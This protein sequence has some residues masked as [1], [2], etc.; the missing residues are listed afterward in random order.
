GRCGREVTCA[1]RAALVQ[2]IGSQPPAKSVRSERKP[3]P[4]ANWNRIAWLYPDKGTPPRTGA[5]DQPSPKCSVLRPRSPSPDSW[6]VSIATAS[7]DEFEYDNYADD[8]DDDDGDDGDD[9]SSDRKPPSQSPFDFGAI[10]SARAS[11]GAKVSS[12]AA[13]RKTKRSDSPTRPAGLSVIRL[14]PASV[15]IF[16]TLLEL[17]PPAGPPNRSSSVPSTGNGS[18]G[19]G[20]GMPTPAEE[21][22]GTSGGFGDDDVSRPMASLAVPEQTTD[23]DQTCDELEDELEDAADL[24]TEEAGLLNLARLGCRVQFDSNVVDNERGVDGSSAGPSGG[25]RM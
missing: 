24:E 18:V 19:S 2:S 12:A 10:A 7:S 5:L 25:A 13:N 8:D 4:L 9:S 20:L 21:P 17:G 11:K 3:Y 23:D 22:A 14:V 1:G 16:Q 15:D 6:S